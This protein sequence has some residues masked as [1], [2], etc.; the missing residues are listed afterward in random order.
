GTVQTFT[1][2]LSQYT[3]QY[4]L[5]D[6][7]YQIQVTVTDEDGSYTATTTVDAELATMEEAIVAQL[8]QDLLGRN[9]DPSGLANWSAMLRAGVPLEQ[10]VRGIVGSPEYRAHVVNQ[11][12]QEYLR[13]DADPSGLA[14]GLTILANGG[15]DALAAMLLGSAEFFNRFG[16]GTNLGFL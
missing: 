4:P 13:R 7:R 3:H 15:P 11:L 2:L 12:Y 1:G 6:S 16:G 14:N 9:A 8:F 10:V 5:A